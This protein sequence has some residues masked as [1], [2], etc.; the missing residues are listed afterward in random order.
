MA[1]EATA[2]AKAS[3][4]SSFKSISQTFV[5]KVGQILASAIVLTLLTALGFAI[6]QMGQ[7]ANVT[8]AAE[9]TWAWGLDFQALN[10]V[11]IGILTAI[12]VASVVLVAFNKIAFAGHV[13]GNAALVYG[14]AFVVAAGWDFAVKKVAV[15][16]AATNIGNMVLAMPGIMFVAFLLAASVVVQRVWK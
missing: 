8:A 9:K 14:V 2:T 16:D 5:S 1:Q 3:V 12:A 4:A 15:L 10:P 13:L 7:G 6:Y 11:Q